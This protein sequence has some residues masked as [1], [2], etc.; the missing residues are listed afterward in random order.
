MFV[1][2]QLIAHSIS[3]KMAVLIIRI[4]KPLLSRGFFL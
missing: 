2:I 3:L 1:S 4:K